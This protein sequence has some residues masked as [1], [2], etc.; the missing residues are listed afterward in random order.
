M[1]QTRASEAT[2]GNLNGDDRGAVAVEFVLILPLLFL[3]LF[4][5][6]AFG[7][8]YSAKMQLTA[9]VREGA[10]VLALGSGDPVVATVDAAPTLDPTNIT[11]VTSDDPCTLGEPATVTANYPLDIGIPFWGSDTVDLY[12]EGVMRC[13]G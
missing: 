13:G 1:K 11:V 9:A 12:A 2:H 5:M 3:L 8:A 6:I 10:R 7:R 4:G